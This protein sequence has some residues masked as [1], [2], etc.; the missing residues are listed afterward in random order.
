VKAGLAP[1]LLALVGL[2]VAGCGSGNQAVPGSVT[3]TGTTTIANVQVGTVIRCK[4]GPAARV[5]HWFG[6]SYL[7]VP[8]RP[9]LI[10]LRHRHGSVVVSCRA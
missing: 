2:T 3:V 1:P 7:R 9:G 10:E 4:G 5:P 8:G 6:P